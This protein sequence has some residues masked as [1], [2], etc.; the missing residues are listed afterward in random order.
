MSSLDAHIHITKPSPA[1]RVPLL[2]L[3]LLLCG[4]ASGPSCYRELTCRDR[5]REASPEIVF[6]YGRPN[7]LL[8]GMQKVAELPSRLML[9]GRLKPDHIP[10]DETR[11][12]LTDYIQE[13]ELADVP[14]FV[15]DYSPLGEWKR[16]RENDRIAPIWK[17]TAGTV[18]LVNYTIMP[19][20]VF[21][22]DDYN[23]FTNSLYFNSGRLTD[24]L[25]A[26]AYAKDIHQREAPGPYATVNSLP[27]LSLWKTTRAVDDIV[28]YAQARDNWQLESGVY[29]DQFPQVAVETMVPAA[30]FMSP[31]GNLALAISG[32]AVGYAVGRS[33]EQQRIA[34]RSAEGDETES[35]GSQTEDEENPSHVEL[36]GHQETSSPADADAEDK[37]QPETDNRR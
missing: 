14:V 17:Y 3:S 21:G 23:P 22:R 19:G 36:A 7:F 11:E 8:D 18:S 32:G 9:G 33:V 12:I 1:T 31:I 16:L 2:V 26:A 30:F 37:A 25:H 4:C 35:R 28:Y 10:T 34:E 24:S 29:R 13:N 20:R 5:L 15:N 6:E 27:L